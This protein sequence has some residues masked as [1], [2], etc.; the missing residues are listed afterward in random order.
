[1]T[2]VVPE[3]DCILQGLSSVVSLNMAVYEEAC[4]NQGILSQVL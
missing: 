3:K 4:N 1:M 2:I